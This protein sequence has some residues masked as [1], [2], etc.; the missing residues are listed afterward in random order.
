MS[1]SKGAVIGA[2]VGLAGMAMPAAVSAKTVTVSA[3]VPAS[4]VKSFKP[5][6]AEVNNFFGEKTTVSVGDTVKWTGLSSNFHTVDIPPKGG[7]AQP[8][9]I[10]GAGKVG[11]VDAAGVPFWFD[12]Y[13]PPI[14]FNP[15]LFAATG[16]KSYNGS[17]RV[18]SGLP[19]TPKQNNFSVKFTKAGTY[20]YFCDVHFGMQGTVVVLSKGKKTPSTTSVTR[21]VTKQVKTDLAEA[22]TLDT[23]APPANTVDLGSAGPG[24]VEVLA[25]FPAAL[26]VSVGGTVTFTMTKDSREVHTGSVGPLA[27]LTGLANSFNSPAFDQEAVYPSSPPAAGPIVVTQTSHGNGFANIGAVTENTA[28]K[29]SPS[30]QIKFNQAG[31]YHFQCLIHPFMTGTITVS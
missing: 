10:P 21:A 4:A 1:R 12:G 23:T 17:G 27:Y 24:G 13:V 25:M 7:S 14:G 20:H 19:F 26:H 29:L 22:K 15:V 18:D 8:L 16:G 30:G 2:V 3:G 9:L 6:G 5:T 31:S 11:A 28:T